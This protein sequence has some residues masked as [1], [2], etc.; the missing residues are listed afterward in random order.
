MFFVNQTLNNTLG[1]TSINLESKGVTINQIFSDNQNW[2]VYRFKHIDELRE[3]EVEEV[4]KMLQCQDDSRGYFL[5]HC[6]NC[7]DVKII[8]LGCNSR[9]CTHCGKKYTDKWAERLARRTFDVTHRHVIMTIAEELRP[10]FEKHHELFKIL[11][12]CAITAISDMLSWTLDR[13]V[14]PGVVVVIH[15][16]GKDMKF[17]PHI[18]CLVTEGGFRY[19]SEWVEL[20]VFP[21]K[22]LRRTW[23]YQI[24]TRFRKTVPDTPEN[25]ALI[26]YLF[27]A[28]PN[29]FYVR[30]KDRITNKKHMI[31]YIGRYIRHPAVA[32]S[33]IEKYD[34]NN[35]T[36]QYVDNDDITHHVT[37]AVGEFISAVIGHIPDRQFKTVRYYGVYYRVKRK[38]FK[39]L[40]CLVSITQG[41]LLKLSEKWAPTCDRCGCV[42]GLVGYFP[43][44][45]PDK[46]VFGEKIGHWYYIGLAEAI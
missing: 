4:E 23:Q 40:L 30:A 24:L 25:R 35:V 5:Y 10:F 45:P 34:G 7:G 36:F 46:A 44:G 6:P 3:V 41:N 37:M 29:G 8:H 17:N 11:M 28:Y 14:T 42:M 21:Y 39:R 13:R 33:R 12:D 31:R 1:Q 43:K 32:E 22:T 38:H 20:G 18:H 27:K 16:Y 9:V 19:N 26:D 2:N 15:T